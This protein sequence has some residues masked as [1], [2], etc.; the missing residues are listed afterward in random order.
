M[1][2]QGTVLLVKASFIIET[3]VYKTDFNNGRENE[4]NDLKKREEIL[5]SVG[6]IN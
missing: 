1:C 6:K 4:G 2:S 5:G 3:D